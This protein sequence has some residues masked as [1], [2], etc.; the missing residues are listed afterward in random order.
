[1]RGEVINTSNLGPSRAKPRG[2][3]EGDT[4]LTPAGAVGSHEI[5][6]TE[7][8]TQEYPVLTIQRDNNRP[9]RLS[10]R[11]I[12]VIRA[13]WPQVEAFLRKHENHNDSAQPIKAIDV[14]DDDDDDQI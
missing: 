11:K 9:I 2:L 13:V 7:D 6:V 10:L 5:V 14:H 3:A 8:G 4:L 12:E 1:M